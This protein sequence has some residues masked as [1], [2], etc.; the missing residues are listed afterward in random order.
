LLLVAVANRPASVIW[1]LRLYEGVL[2]MVV[3]PAVW[4]P[5][6]C[7]HAACRIALNGSLAPDSWG[8]T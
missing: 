6:V 5:R 8:A 2:G 1:G 3:S 4:W 7:S